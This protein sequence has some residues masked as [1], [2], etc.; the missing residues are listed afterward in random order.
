[1]VDAAVNTG[2]MAAV[3]GLGIAGVIAYGRIRGG[4]EEDE[5]EDE[6]ESEEQD[7]PSVPHPTT[8]GFAQSPQLR[9]ALSGAS[10]GL[11]IASRNWRGLGFRVVGLRRVDA[12]TGG[13]VS[14]RSAL[15]G[16]FF[17]QGC[18]AATGL[19]FD[20]AHSVSEPRWSPTR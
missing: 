5:D 11:A 3:V 1:M 4:E 12:R 6:R 16:V 20:R 18:Q 7:E 14:V 13:V 17:D 2:S 10:A 15:I 9:A 8:R 19:L